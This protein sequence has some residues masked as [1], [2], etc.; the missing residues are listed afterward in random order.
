ME[1]Q[2]V[3]NYTKFTQLNTTKML[4]LSFYEAPDDEKKKIYPVAPILREELF[5]RT[6]ENDP[7]TAISAWAHVYLGRLAL[8]DKDDKKANEQFNAALA[9]EGISAVAREA[10]E[11]GLESSSSTGDKQK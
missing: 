5:Q 8:A 7:G 6:A 9:T 2:A 1:K 10:A 4:A 3:V 11:K